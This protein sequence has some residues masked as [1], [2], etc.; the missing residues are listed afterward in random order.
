MNYIDVLPH[1]RNNVFFVHIVTSDYNMSKEAVIRVTARKNDGSKKTEVIKIPTDVRYEN[2]NAYIKMFGVSKSVISQITAVRVNGVETYTTYTDIDEDIKARYDD[3]LSRISW[4]EG[5]NNIKLDFDVIGNNPM[6]LMVLDK[7]E[8]GILADRPAVI[9]VITPD[10]HEM[11]HYLGK[12]QIN[13]FDSRTLY[14][15]SSSAGQRDAKE[16]DPVP[17]GLYFID[18]TGS[19]SNYNFNRYHLKTDSMRLWMSRLW[20]NAY[21]LEGDDQKEEIG[22]IKKI[23]FLL[24]A[25]ESYMRL[26][27]PSEAKNIFSSAKEMAERLFNC[28]ECSCAGWNMGITGQQD[29]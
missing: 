19:P 7:S 13:V 1:I 5:M 17:D 20:A 10:G 9:K 26:G 27:N 11:V 15:A 2:G 23:E 14:N 28:G 25:A 24:L 8:W 16:F 3:S 22:K 4:T 21:G 12:N 29:A 18:I 6:N